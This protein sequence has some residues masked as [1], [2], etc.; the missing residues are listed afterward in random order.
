MM[1]ATVST[2]MPVFTFA[3]LVAAAATALVA[4]GV[5]M[6]RRKRH[7]WLAVVML[8]LC[9]PIYLVSAVSVLFALAIADCPPDAYEC[10]F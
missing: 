5:F 4:G 9:A 1:L 2:A 6:V 7:V 3:A 8:V 10:P